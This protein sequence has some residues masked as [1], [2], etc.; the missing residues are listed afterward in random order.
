MEVLRIE[1]I[2]GDRFF[3]SWERAASLKDI[4]WNIQPGLEASRILPRR[5]DCIQGRGNSLQR[6]EREFPSAFEKLVGDSVFRGESLSNGKQVQSSP[7]GSLSPWVGIR[8][9]P[10]QAAGPPQAGPATDS[11][12]PCSFSPASSLRPA[13]GS[14]HSDLC[15]HPVW[16]EGYTF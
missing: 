5:A 10:H 14:H 2:S 8:V 15:T 1:L 9:L 3:P 4:Q 16:G 13:L 11:S 7:Q 12:L 6:M